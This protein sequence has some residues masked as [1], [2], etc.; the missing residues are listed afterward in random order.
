MV[1]THYLSVLLC[2][3]PQKAAPPIGS[4]ASLCPIT[5]YF[6]GCSIT[7]VPN[8]GA[9]GKLRKSTPDKA[10]LLQLEQ[11]DVVCGVTFCSFP[12]YPP[13]FE[14]VWVARAFWNCYFW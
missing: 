3:Q 9:L 7:L 13:D 1:V 14:A 8:A 10:Q 5:I 4:A 6:T 2:A 12:D 11:A